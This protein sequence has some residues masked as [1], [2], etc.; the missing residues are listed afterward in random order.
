MNL[1]SMK[2]AVE[3]ARVTMVR[4]DLMADNLAALLIGRLRY[5]SSSNLDQLKREIS[6]FNLRT[7]EWKR[8]ER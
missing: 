8:G 2:E 1:E 4:A 5:V 3:D 6:G 7:W